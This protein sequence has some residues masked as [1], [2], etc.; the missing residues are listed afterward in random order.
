MDER[1]PAPA[2]QIFF[3][4]AEVFQPALIEKTKVAFRIRAVEK[5]RSSVNNT[6]QLIVGGAYW[7]K[8]TSIACRR[9][10]PRFR[11]AL[12]GIIVRYACRASSETY[13]P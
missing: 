3:T 9:V 2:L 8:L 10:E 12:G 5:C 13:R 7:L 6:P 11:K 1:S 4:D